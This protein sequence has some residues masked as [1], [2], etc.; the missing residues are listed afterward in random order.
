MLCLRRPASA[1][2]QPARRPALPYADWQLER[3]D[4]ANHRGETLIL[5][6]G[7]DVLRIG[8][9]RRCEITLF[10]ATAS[11]EHATLRRD[12]DGT[13]WLSP[14]AGK[15]VSAD[16]EPVTEPVELCEGL[17]LRLGNDQ[18]RCRRARAHDAGHPPAAEDGPD[19]KPAVFSRLV[20]VL[21]AA[22]LLVSAALLLWGR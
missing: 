16:G 6:P 17:S 14:Q 21:L 3:I 18:L 15:A 5:E 7:A 19:S 13:W 22:L 12:P 20:W 8:R 1:L 9:S 2:A 10:T 11:R 4:P